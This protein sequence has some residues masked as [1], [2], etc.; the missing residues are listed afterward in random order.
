MV[1]LLFSISRQKLFP[2]LL[3]G[4]FPLFVLAGA[5]LDELLAVGP[6]ALAAQGRTSRL[7]LLI[8]GITL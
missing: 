3:T 6:S 1:F 2:Y 5:R 7:V 8:V 4:A